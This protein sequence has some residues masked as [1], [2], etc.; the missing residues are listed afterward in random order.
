MFFFLSLTTDVCLLSSLRQ[1]LLSQLDYD[2]LNP[3][4]VSGDELKP[5][6]KGTPSA[7]CSFCNAIYLPAMKG[8]KCVVCEMAEVGKDVVGLTIKK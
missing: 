2:P 6:Y 3:F 4:S 1:L 5:V 7:R 8:T